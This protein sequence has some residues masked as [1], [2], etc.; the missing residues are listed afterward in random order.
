MHRRSPGCGHKS[1]GVELWAFGRFLDNGLQWHGW[2]CLEDRA[3]VHSKINTDVPAPLYGDN[4]VI[5][6]VRTCNE[7]QCPMCFNVDIYQD[8]TISSDSVKQ[9][10]RLKAEVKNG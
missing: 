6:F 3:W 10:K 2:T 9:L 1:D 5:E 8:G 4:Q 7:H